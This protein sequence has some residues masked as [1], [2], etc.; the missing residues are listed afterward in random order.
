[1]LAQTI[2]GLAKEFPQG[3]EGIQMM[4]QGLQK[5]QSSAAQA[6]A[7]SPVTAPPR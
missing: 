4:M 1:M 7:P 6:S 2:Q 3:Q 5:L